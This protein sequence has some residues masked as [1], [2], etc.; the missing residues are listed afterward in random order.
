MS[1]HENKPDDNGT[2]ETHAAPERTTVLEFPCDF[3]VKMMGKNNEEFINKSKEIINEQFPEQKDTVTFKAVPSK[4]NNYL[5]ISAKVVANS[6][7]AL[8]SCYQALT[9]EPLVLI[10]L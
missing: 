2:N 9:D 1:E 4:D 10:A 5:A 3:V 6:Q 7:E 8:D